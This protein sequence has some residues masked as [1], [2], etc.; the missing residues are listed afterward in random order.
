M[1]SLGQIDSQDKMENAKEDV[2]STS[3]P[4]NVSPGGPTK[5]YHRYFLFVEGN[6]QVGLA[7]QEAQIG[8]IVCQFHDCD[9]QVLVRRQGLKYVLIGR[10]LTAKRCDE[11]PVRFGDGGSECFKYSIPDS[12]S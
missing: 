2:L 10:S 3:L 6:D 7:P 12:G 4:K 1:G 5:A 8:N 9:V 11:E